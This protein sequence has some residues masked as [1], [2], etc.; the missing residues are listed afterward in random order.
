MY[1]ASN[2]KDIRRAEKEAR[3]AE[4]SRLDYLRSAMSTASGRA[5]FHDLLEACH[6]FSDP[7]TGNPYSEAYLKGERNVGLRIFADITAN[8][9]DD[10]I[11]MMKEANGRRIE[12]A[13]R[14]GKPGDSTAPNSP[15]ARTPDGTLKD[16]TTTSTAPPPS[17]PD[18]PATPP[19]QPGAPEKYEFVAPEGQT[20]DPAVLDQ[21][22][23]IFKELGLSQDAAAKL[24]AKQFEREAKFIKDVNDM[25][26]GWRAQVERDFGGQ[27]EAQ[28]ADVG[29]MKD[30][31]F[32]NDTKARQDFDNAMN[33]TGAGDHPA[34][35]SAFVKMSEAFREGSHVSGSG[36]SR[37]GQTEPR[38]PER[39][40]AAQ[41]MYPNLS[42]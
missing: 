19:V 2:R 29:R 27:R 7:F 9:P 8:C 36:P 14:A 41:A 37:H 13:I 31:I 25:R 10:Y 17:P 23:P 33:L 18:A 4:I 5:W 21:F 32:G 26:A 38:A 15:E 1:D 40:T 35:V 12:H 28:L 34:I 6:L 3:Q 11:L 42:H 30:A 16:T 22:T 20:M 24:V 39:P